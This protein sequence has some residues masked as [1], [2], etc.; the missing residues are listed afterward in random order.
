METIISL[1]GFY[2]LALAL[3]HTGFWKFFGWKTDLAKLKFYNRGI[4]QILNIQLIFSF[5]FTAVVC[6]YFSTDLLNSELGK[7][8]LGANSLFWL[9]RTLQQFIFL[10]KNHYIIHILTV[11][12]MLGIILF[13]LPLF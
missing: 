8:F 4:M 2:S 11:V 13:A 10:K 12:F 7:W 3:F 6:F 5:S 9:L 1:C